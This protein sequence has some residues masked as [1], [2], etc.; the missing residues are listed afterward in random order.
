VIVESP[1]GRHTLEVSEQARIDDL[2][3]GLLEVC[4]AGSDPAGWS[5]APMGEPALRWDRTIK[6][7]GLFPGAV[8]ELVAPVALEQIESVPDPLSAA[9]LARR[10]RAQFQRTRRLPD[11]ARMGDAAYRRMLDDAIAAPRLGAGTVVA[12]MSAH[13]GAGT[14]TVAVLLATLLSGLRG[15]QVVA[16]DL[17]SQSGA[18][19]H[20]IAPESGPPGAKYRALLMATSAPE[21]VR[22]ALVKLTP[23]LA[24]LPA[25][26]DQLGEPADADWGRLIVHLRHLHNIVILDCGTGFQ[27]PVNR[28]ALV[29]ADQVVL[30]GTSAHGDLEQLRP[31]IE[32]I[33]RQGRTVAVVA[34]QAPQRLRAR[35]ATSG[36]QL[37]TLAYEPQPALRLKTRGFS[38][39]EAPSSWQESVREL[40][41]ILIA[42]GQAPS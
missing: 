23:T 9:E 6:E 17:C 3:P 31:A 34:N 39:P 38:W 27:R 26:I 28:A 16:V 41:A 5:L 29:A 35:P 32:A 11:T 7:C 4:E 30:V 21:Q 18:L 1:S 36:V 33:Q 12:V 14:T 22:A 20:W 19:S 25:P 40:A 2:V 24:V 10:L 13:A 15:D 8:L 42:S 37:V